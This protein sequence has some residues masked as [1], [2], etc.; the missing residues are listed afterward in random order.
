MLSLTSTEISELKEKYNKFKQELQSDIKNRVITNLKE[1]YLIKKKWD[2]DISNIFNSNIG[3]N[4]TRRRYRNSNLGNNSV[5]LPND[6]PEFIN[7]FNSFF[8]CLENKEKITFANCDLINSIMKKYSFRVNYEKMKYYAGNNKIILEP[9]NFGNTYEI[10]L[11]END[12]SMLE[13]ISNNT[14]INKIK[15]QFVG[16]IKSR[17]KES[18]KQELYKYLIANSNHNNLNLDSFINS[19]TD[20][21]ILEPEI[22]PPKEDKKVFP[23][24]TENGF[25]ISKTGRRHYR[26]YGESKVQDEKKN[27][28]ESQR[29]NKKEE[30]KRYIRGSYRSR[31]RPIEDKK[32]E[33]D[34]PKINYDQKR[35]EN[36]DP[37]AKPKWSRAS[38]IFSQ[39][40]KT[41]STIQK[42]DA[43]PEQ[44]KR[45]L[46]KL[47]KENE[48]LINSNNEL[49]DKNY[50]LNNDLR[51]NSKEIT[52][53][54]REINTLKS[55]INQKDSQINNLQ[56]DL[57]NIKKEQSTSKFQSRDNG[58]SL[59]RTRYAFTTQP[60]PEKD[61]QK[62]IDKYEKEKKDLLKKIEDFEK[63]N[64]EIQKKY[65]NKCQES[66]ALYNENKTFKKSE[67]EFN[68]IIKELENKI[69]KLE[70][71]KNGQISNI[72]YELEEKNKYNKEILKEN[73]KLKD[74]E[75]KNLNQIK[76]LESKEKNYLSKIKE[77]ELNMSK[78]EKEFSK[79]I[80]NLENEKK[81]LEKQ[82]SKIKEDYEK[83]YK[84]NDELYEENQNL[85]AKEEEYNKTIKELEN[86]IK[87]NEKENK[88]NILKLES[89]NKEIISKIRNELNDK[90]YYIE[91]LKKENDKLKNIEK[92][93]MQQ[94]K[95]YENELE[96]L[97]KD[98]S[99]IAQLNNNLSDINDSLKNKEKEYLAQIKNLE[100]QLK[101]KIDKN[102]KLTEKKIKDIN[103]KIMFV[104]NRENE[105]QSEYQK[106]ESTKQELEKLRKELDEE[107]KNILNNQKQINNNQMQMNSNQMQI[108]NNQ[109]QM[110]NNPI[111]SN[112]MNNKNII[113]N[114][115]MNVMNV[116]N[117]GM[118]AFNFMPNPMNFGMVPNPMFN[119]NN[120]NNINN[121]NNNNI[122]QFNKFNPITIPKSGKQSQS[123]PYSAPTLIGLN[124]IGATCYLNATLQ[125]LSQTEALTKYFLN[126]KNKDKIIDNNI[127]KKN[128]NELQLCPVY[129]NLIQNLWKKNSTSKSFSPNQFMNTI[130]AM[131]PLFKKGQAGDSK[132]F[133]IFILEQFHRE[134]K[135]T[136][137]NNK[138]PNRDLNQYD[139]SIAFEHFFYEFK[140]ELSV[141]SD[142]FFGFN[143]TTNVC[144][145][146]KN[147][148][149]S[150]NMANP[151]CYN[152]GIFN[153][154]I[155]P[156]E[157]VKNLRNRNNFLLS[158]NNMVN[159]Y[160]CFLYNQKTDLFT[161]ENKNYCNI[162]RKLWDSEY[163]SR[164]YSSPNVLILI[165]N[166]GKNNIYKV[167]IDFAETIDISPFVLIQNSSQIYNLYGVITHLGE[168]GPNAHFVASCKSPIDKKWYRYND[169]M[170]T[171][172][173]DF[174]KEIYNFG[175]P[176][177]LFY[178]KAS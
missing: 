82:Y 117:R 73:D 62:I 64:F 174:M 33:N 173:Y 140:N 44:L 36:N 131:N 48:K 40:E 43:N 65:E 76:E 170:V 124:N 109:M 145:N 93:N 21:K 71:E 16:F 153:V 6:P 135:H 78:K 68:K 18:K 10:L 150:K 74:N 15:Y 90:M 52:K 1:C 168:S 45:E 57:N 66:E 85:K 136:A 79:K 125:C 25:E 152:Y 13:G 158:N 106:I 169:A 171:P 49:R 12:F 123:L 176:Y 126:E 130:E 23:S 72:S 51:E 60:Q 164:I 156:L 7:D 99:E 148:Y 77:Y 97:K 119:Q 46:E 142:I 47:K 108:N 88:N 120:F 96:E 67:K 9:Q 69:I 19:N 83:E 144:L 54:N 17:M 5:S 34:N 155:F 138:Q 37:I 42:M 101:Q 81:E 132:D 27:V 134:L 91:E 98:N 61:Y 127:A 4:D 167:K 84:E 107:K 114:N 137:E 128:R 35:E 111:N 56:N 24:S 151:I 177:I 11:I 29:E 105:L 41:E 149:N 129:L 63:K 31:I 80:I 86:T 89:E 39:R 115:D 58:Y 22:E 26:K 2:T 165:L 70:K 50:S 122:N 110:N 3:G 87:I 113:I 116:H 146:C 162:C 139:K 175:N 159:L 154:I 161:G 55:T 143:E 141:I 8:E 103:E 104:E 75:R 166:R 178:Q 38:S 147:I 112:N 160:D 157:E 28:F 133:I 100:K 102:D 53:L 95:K 163:T 32:E 121:N 14:K 172:I 92:N 94:I 59:R 30:P 118:E 20:I